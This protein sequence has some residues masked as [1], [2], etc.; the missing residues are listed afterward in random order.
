[1]LPGWGELGKK[2]ENTETFFTHFYWLVK[3]LLERPSLYEGDP[4]MRRM[5]EK[6]V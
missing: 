5:R 4:K 6:G 1:M 2:V 3:S